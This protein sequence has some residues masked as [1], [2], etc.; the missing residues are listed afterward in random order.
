M[1]TVYLATRKEQFLPSVLVM[2]VIFQETFFKQ[3]VAQLSTANAMLDVL[4]E[5]HEN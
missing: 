5:H 4:T 1:L 3:Y 2:D